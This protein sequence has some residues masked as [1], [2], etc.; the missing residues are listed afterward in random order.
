MTTEKRF[1][2]SN[3]HNGYDGYDDYAQAITYDYIDDLYECDTEY[4]QELDVPTY[5][6][7]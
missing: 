4:D 5:I 2:E 1:V 6:R 7:I 3:N